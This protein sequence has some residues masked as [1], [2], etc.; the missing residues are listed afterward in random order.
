MESPPHPRSVR[1]IPGEIESTVV[2]NRLLVPTPTQP[3]WRPFRRVAESVA[4][5]ARQLPAH[6]HQSEEV[7]TYV[8]D[9]FASYQLEGGNMEPLPRGSGRLLTVPGRASHR[10]SPGTGGAIRWFNLVLSLPA[11]SAGDV[12]LQ[13]MDAQGPILKEDQVHVR[14]IVGSG[15]QMASAAGLECHEL[16]FTDEA[17]TFRKIGSDHRAFLYATAGRGSVDQRA[18][19]AGEVAFIEGM[20]GVAVQGKPGFSAILATAPR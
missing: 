20:P 2:T 17:T 15:A 19:E 7:L 16:Q 5:R 8:T 11:G 4:N 14:P 10:I 13:L 6:S 12:R 18:I 9:G 3:E 1:V